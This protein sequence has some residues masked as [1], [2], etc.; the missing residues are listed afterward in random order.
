MTQARFAIMAHIS[1]N[2]LPLVR[3]LRGCGVEPFVSISSFQP[4]RDPRWKRKGI[5]EN[6][7]AIL[8]SGMQQSEEWVV[9]LH[10]DAII[11]S[12]FVSKVLHVLSFATGD[13]VS[14]FNPPNKS[15]AKARADGHHVVETAANYWTVCFCFRREAIRH[16]YDWGTEHIIVGIVSEDGYLRRYCTREGKKVQVVVPSLVQ[17]DLRV[18]STLFNKVSCGGRRRESVAYDPDFDVFAV[19]WAGEF[20]TPYQDNKRNLKTNGLMGF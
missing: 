14:F 4:T 9:L 20:Q 3:S 11:C 10:D 7:R 17:H 18:K 6:F 8:A 5:Y 12:D 16:I 1:R 13:M 2:H 15:F 19:N